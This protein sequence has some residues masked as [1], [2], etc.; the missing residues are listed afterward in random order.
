MHETTVSRMS[1]ELEEIKAAV[2]RLRDAQVGAEW[3]CVD[4]AL[5]RIWEVACELQRRIEL[6]ILTAGCRRDAVDQLARLYELLSEGTLGA[7]DDRQLAGLACA[8][9]LA[10]E[11]IAIY[12]RMAADLERLEQPKEVA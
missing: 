1:G 7:L 11:K 5:A 4:E 2:V 8:C 6:P 10:Q 9:E 12:Q 3:P